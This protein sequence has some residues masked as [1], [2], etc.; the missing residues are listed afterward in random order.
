M[1]GDGRR[2][3]R[4]H[5]QVLHPGPRPVGEV[6]RDAGRDGGERADLPAAR[7]RGV[8]RRRRPRRRREPDADAR[9]G[10]RPRRRPRSS[11]RACTSATAPSRCCAA[12]I[13]R[14]P[15]GATVAVVGAT[16]S[17][18]STVIKLLTRLYERDRGAIRIDGVDIRDLPLA[19]LRRRITVVSQDVILFAGTL[20]DNIALGKPYDRAQLDEAVRRVGLDRALAR[21]GAD[22]DDAG[23][24]A[25]QQLLRRRAPA[26][27]VRARAAPRSRDPHPRRGDRARRPGGRGADR[28][29]RRRADE[30]RARRSSSRTGCRPSATPT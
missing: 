20:A 5:Q 25:R 30:G 6:R 26:R 19:E 1:I 22:V 16:G 8:R 15:R 29:R 18:K 7:H 13:S 12:S 10:A 2:V 27:R 17:G 11:S 24:R 4:V 9:D 28:A 23:R 3:H 21:R 14:V